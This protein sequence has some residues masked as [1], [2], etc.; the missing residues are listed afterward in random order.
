ML[1]VLFAQT[2]ALHN[3]NRSQRKMHDY[4]GSDLY[5]HNA[6]NATEKNKYIK[7]RPPSGYGFTRTRIEKLELAREL[8]LSNTLAHSRG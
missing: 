8:R 1:L 5:A 2:S 4:F 7:V 3:R 6:N